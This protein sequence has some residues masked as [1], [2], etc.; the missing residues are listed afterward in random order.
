MAKADR[1]P[2]SHVRGSEE[3][4]DKGSGTC[5]L[6]QVLCPRF[7]RVTMPSMFVPLK[8]R[9]G[10]SW[11]LAAAI[12]L[13]MAS[14]VSSFANTILQYKGAP[15]TFSQPGEIDINI[16]LNG[17][18]QPNSVYESDEN[19][20]LSG[21][22]IDTEHYYAGTFAIWDSI[23]TTDSAG[24]V[25][26]WD[27]R[28]NPVDGPNRG[29]YNCPVALNGYCSAGSLGDGDSSGQSF[30]AGTW[31]CSS[32]CL[33]GSN[34]TQNATFAPEPSTYALLLIGAGLFCML[35]K[36]IRQAFRGNSRPA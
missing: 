17:I 26:S 21:F 19:D 23:F 13:S 1:E 27:I 3:A 18:I 14:P 36:R 7:Y 29:S 10:A 12:L 20:F 2:L 31:L 5:G 32:D 9:L 11:T 30:V 25:A 8:A 4:S 24:N 34:T 33:V 28:S 15:F 22:L 6:P 35:P 16:T